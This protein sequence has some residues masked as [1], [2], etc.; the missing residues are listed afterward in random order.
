MGFVQRFAVLCFM[1]VLGLTQAQA[2]GTEK[3][4]SK[5]ADGVAGADIA[6]E[7]GGPEAVLV[8]VVDDLLAVGEFEHRRRKNL[9]A[10]RGRRHRARLC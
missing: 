3:D 10:R 6:F 5:A 7:V 8:G 1:L 2:A 4:D 9:C